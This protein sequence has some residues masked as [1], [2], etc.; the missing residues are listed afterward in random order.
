MNSKSLIKARQY[1]LQEEAKV[2]VRDVETTPYKLKL[3]ILLDRYSSEIF[4]N[5]GERVLSNIFYTPIQATD[6]TFQTTSE[7]YM[8][9]TKWDLML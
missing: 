9:I 2:N 8:D 7:A 5:K 6:I 3:R 1:E 4:L